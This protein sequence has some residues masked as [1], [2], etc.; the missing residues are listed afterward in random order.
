LDGKMEQHVKAVGM[1]YADLASA[2]AQS[3]RGMQLLTGLLTTIVLLMGSYLVSLDVLTLGEL[4]AFYVGSTTL[5]VHI[6]KL[7]GCVSQ[8]RG[9]RASVAQI[10]SVLSQA[11]DSAEDASV[12]MPQ[13]AGLEITKLTYHGVDAVGELRCLLKDVTLVI[14][15]GQKVRTTRHA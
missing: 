9:S 15:P 2:A 14:S 5:G 11:S 4:L 12:V 10:E 13:E 1:G 6:V 7:A 8:F 3:E